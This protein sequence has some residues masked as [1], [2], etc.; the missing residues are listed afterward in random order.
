MQCDLPKV[1][2]FVRNL[3]DGCHAFKKPKYITSHVNFFKCRPKRPLNQLRIEI[4]G[5]DGIWNNVSLDV[6]E[7]DSLLFCLIIC[8]FTSFVYCKH[9]LCIKLNIL[10][11][12][13]CLSLHHVSYNLSFNRVQIFS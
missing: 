4:K 6:M 10:L 9:I 1:H 13:Y 12:V 5:Q 2:K 3:I 11:I 8:T 7:V